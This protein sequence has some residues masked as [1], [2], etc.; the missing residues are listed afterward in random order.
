MSWL[1]VGLTVLAALVGLTEEGRASVVALAAAVHEGF[2]AVFV[3]AGSFT[4][5]CF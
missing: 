3:D 2:L 1:E 4:T 5:G